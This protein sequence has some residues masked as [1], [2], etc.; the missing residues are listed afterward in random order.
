MRC[1]T[2]LVS[3]F[4]SA[5]FELANVVRAVGGSIER[6][7]RGTYGTAVDRTSLEL[8]TSKQ[9]GSMLHKLTASL[10]L[11]FQWQEPGQRQSP[12][13]AVTR[14]RV[15]VESHCN[16]DRILFQASGEPP[17]TRQKNTIQLLVF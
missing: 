1:L 10:D 3:L 6:V 17:T 9:R 14:T 12:A 8:S 13:V 11:S 16:L 4:A 2:Q 7:M 15:T 5:A